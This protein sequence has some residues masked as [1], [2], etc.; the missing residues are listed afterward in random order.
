MKLSAIQVDLRV[1]LL[2]AIFGGLW[3]LL[4]DR[5]YRP[6]WPREQALAYTFASQCAF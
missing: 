2:Y 3:I 5:P 4:S 1:A 6:G